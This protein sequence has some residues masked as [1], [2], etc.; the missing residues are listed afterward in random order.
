[1]FPAEQQDRARIQ[2]SAVLNAVISQRLL[3]N[4]MGEVSIALEYLLLTPAVRNLIRENKLH[5]IYG[6]MQVG[7]DKTGMMTMNQS[8]L[9]LILKRRI[10]VRTAFTV[11]PDP[12][13]L[14]K[15]MQKAG[16]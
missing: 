15:L 1:M 16:L 7:Q 6:I 11:T 12:D 2:L 4:K 10:D 3:P 9:N 13:E 8:L 14:D 5:Q